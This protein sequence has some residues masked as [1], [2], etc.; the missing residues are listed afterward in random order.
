MAASPLYGPPGELLVILSDP[1]HRTFGL[2]IGHMFSELTYFFCAIAPMVGVV[3]VGL[4]SHFLVELMGPP[5]LYREPRSSSP[6]GAPRGYSP[7][8]LLGDFLPESATCGITWNKQKR[9]L[10][11][12]AWPPTTRVPN[13][14][15]AL[16]TGEASWRPPARAIPHT[17]AT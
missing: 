4:T 7:L 10:P 17:I 13:R 5:R 8:P 16:R 15:R 2:W 12:G 9:F 11:Q 14:G 3:N 1:N 6:T